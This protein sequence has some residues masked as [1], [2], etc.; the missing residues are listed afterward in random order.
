M[1]IFLIAESAK[2]DSVFKL[3]ITIIQKEFKVHL[4]YIGCLSDC[5]TCIDNTRCQACNAGFNIKYFSTN[6][7]CTSDC[8]SYYFAE[9]GKCKSN[10]ILCK[11]IIGCLTFC[12]TCVEQNRCKQCEFTYNIKIFSTYD[13]CTNDCGDEYFP[14][15][16][17]CNSKEIIYDRMI[18]NHQFLLECLANCKMCQNNLRC[19]SCLPGFYFKVDTYNDICT[20]DCGD[21]YY[22]DKGI[23]TSKTFFFK[24]VIFII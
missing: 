16:G 1:S 5:K 24:I 14:G 20:T 19:D 21:G 4:I 10:I 18:S 11:T 22:P 6:D 9:S 12:E 15:Q 3:E 13:I 7:V 2:V 23:C 17:K 8:G